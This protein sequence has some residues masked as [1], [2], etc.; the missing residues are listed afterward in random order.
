MKANIYYITYSSIPSELPSSLQIIKTCEG[1]SKNKN[2]VTLIKPGT[3]NKKISIRK[4][5]DLKENINIKEFKSIKDFPRGIKFYLYSFYCLFYILKKKDPIIITR[6][7]F[8]SYLLL[9][10]NIKVILEVHHDTN[11]EGRVNKFIL[12]YLNFFKKKK[13]TKIIAISNSVKNLFVKKYSVDPKK[14]IVLPSGSSIRVNKPPRFSF[15]KRLKIGYFGSIAYS[16]GI[17]TLI[18]LS[19]IDQENDYYIFGGKKE[20]LQ[21]FKNRNS[22]KNLFFREHI[23]YNLLPKIMMTMDI[24]TIPYTRT[25]NSAGGVDDISHYTSPLKLFD[26]M[27][28]G[29]IIISSNL[30]VLREVI[31]HRN[32]YFINNFE[33]IFEWKRKIEI[34]KNNKI[35]SLIMRKNNLILSKKF[36]HVERVKKYI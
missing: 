32:A 24:L 15:N 26:Y 5:Y 31:G 28:V 11:I 14:I 21:K 7:Y 10:F 1:L 27:A 12:N 29:K 16:K 3:G 25:V 6:N 22:N 2:L 4:F 13:L 17:N 8:V 35:K 33:N 20:E 36:N 30:K 34:A 23:S 19:K 9:I 18:K